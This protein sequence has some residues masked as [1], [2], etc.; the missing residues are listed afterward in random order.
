MSESHKCHAGS[1]TISSELLEQ[2][3]QRAT[4]AE[5]NNIILDHVGVISAIPAQAGEV[6]D[7]GGAELTL[8]HEEQLWLYV[9]IEASGQIRR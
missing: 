3:L 4:S 1:D 9:C 6:K 5:I 7:D 2:M 8:G